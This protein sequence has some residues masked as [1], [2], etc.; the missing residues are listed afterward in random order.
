MEL[1]ELVL[2]LPSMLKWKE[3]V[4]DMFQYIKAIRIQRK[5]MVS[6]K[7]NW[8]LANC[9]SCKIVHYPYYYNK[10]DQYQFCHQVLA[11]FLDAFDTY[12]NFKEII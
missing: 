7:V 6:N 2:S 5:D 9:W 12:A 1:V 8:L 4:V 3:A 11:D 10:Q